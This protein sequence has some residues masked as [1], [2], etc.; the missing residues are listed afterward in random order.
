M[1]KKI[2]GFVAAVLAGNLALIFSA[3]ADVINL[4]CRLE[5]GNS[6]QLAPRNYWLNTGDMTATM[7]GWI[8]IQGEDP[9]YVFS[10]PGLRTS[11]SDY[12][13]DFSGW[14]T[15]INRMSGIMTM[16]MP[17]H[18]YQYQCQVGAN[19]MPASKF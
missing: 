17:P 4:I 6:G 3:Q 15:S 11:P 14:H 8:G 13:W 5:Y 1:Y 16:S 9:N 12:S 18:S 2:T 7:G 19:A 10:M